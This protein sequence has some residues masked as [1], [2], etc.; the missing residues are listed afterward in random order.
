MLV[1]YK[2]TSFQFYYFTDKTLT[3]D[4]L[5]ETYPLKLKFKIIKEDRDLERVLPNVILTKLFKR[6]DSKNVS[7]I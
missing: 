5:D 3:T 6:N 1:G 2:P 7:L 4:S